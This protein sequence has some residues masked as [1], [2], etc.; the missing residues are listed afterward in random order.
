[1]VLV[2][3]PRGGPSSVELGE[4]LSGGLGVEPVRRVVLNPWRHGLG[5]ALAEAV[6]GLRFGRLEILRSKFKPGRKLSAYYRMESPEAPVHLAAT[7]PAVDGAGACEVS[8][9]VSPADPAMPQLARLTDGDHL[10]R[11]VCTLTGGPEPA[12]EGLRI[13]TIRYRPGERHVL[14]ATLGAGRLRVVVKTDRDRSGERAVPVARAVT[15]LLRS[16]CPGVLAAEALGWLP[17]D[18]ASVWAFAPGMRL[19]QGLVEVARD[20]TADV[21]LL[22]RALR[23]LH[24]D[25]GTAEQLRASGCALPTLDVAAQLVGTQRAAEHIRVLLPSV[26]RAVDAVVSATAAALTTHHPTA[27]TLVHGDLKSDNVLIGNAVRL[28]DLDRA[29]LGDPAVDL[30]K[31][32]ADLSWWRPG[33]LGGASG[34]LAAFRGGYGPGAEDRWA[35]ADALLPIFQLRFAARRCAVHERDW[36]GRVEALVSA[37][38]TAGTGS[39]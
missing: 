13:D 6:P 7:W 21:A 5:A 4:V 25:T 23:L 38:P 10:A 31:F 27:P 28:L 12:S 17:A 36:Q 35:R 32:V 34:T 33:R 3:P 9:V 24:D 15:A 26:G 11:A 29:G 30:A 39:R 19:S 1:V 20:T 14:G 8:V 2:A 37:V 18:A 16:K 22:G